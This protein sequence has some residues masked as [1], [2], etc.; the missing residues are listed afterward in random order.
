MRFIRL[1]PV[2]VI[3]A[4]M[5]GTSLRAQDAAPDTTNLALRTRL[6][7]DLRNL[8]TAQEAYYAGHSAYAPSLDGL[9]FRASTGSQIALT[10]TQNNAWGAMAT[11]PTWPGKSCV[12]YVNLAEKYRPKTAQNKYSGGDGQVVC[13]GDPQP[14]R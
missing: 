10:A 9:A 7:S 8:V 12:V 4:V 6:K 13:D 14:T 1:V 5:L 2:L 3:P 11:D